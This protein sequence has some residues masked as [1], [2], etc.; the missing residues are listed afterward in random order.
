MP[1][2]FVG[3]VSQSHNVRQNF[4]R[5]LLEF[6]KR[7][8]EPFVFDEIGPLVIA[9]RGL[10]RML[11]GGDNG[12]VLG[13]VAATT[14]GSVAQAIDG[15][16][17]ATPGS[18]AQR[19][20]ETRWGGYVAAFVSPEGQVGIWRAPLG[21]L[22]CYFNRTG[23]DLIV[24][25]SP[26]LIAHCAARPARIDQDALT[27]HLSFAHQRLPVTCL[28][29][30]EELPGGQCL[31]VMAR[32]V[33]LEILWSPWIWTERER[34]IVNPE[35][36][37]SR[38]RATAQACVAACAYSHT[39]ILLKLSGGLDSSIVAACLAQAGLRFRALTLVTDEATG[40]ER[41]YARMVSAHFGVELI[42]VRR[43]PARVDLSRSPAGDLARPSI[44]LFRQESERIA[45]DAARG[46]G[47]PLLMDGGGGDNVFC[48]LQ[49]ASPVA[50]CLLSLGGWRR[51]GAT[52]SSVAEV[53]QVSIAQ[54]VRAAVRRAARRSR[55]HRWPVERSFLSHDA[56]VRLPAKPAHP[57]LRAPQGT[58]P[59]RA[60]HVALIAA[61]QSYVEGLD[62]EREPHLAV[63]LLAQPL[64]E[65]CL[66]IPSWLWF[67][68]GLSRAIARRAFAD[69]LPAAIV[70]RR[71]KGTPDSFVAQVFE[72]NR[73][74]ICDELLGGEL[75][76]LGLLDRAALARV[77]DSRRPLGDRYL[78][79]IMTLYDA[80]IWCRAWH[81]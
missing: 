42:E 67:E 77:L 43:D 1:R 9:S 73:V 59:G 71:S 12:L 30:I 60:A 28:E 56:L 15:N 36:A 66:R 20:I 31:T 57:W 46:A 63:P 34:A 29:D 65:L 13:R 24:A 7:P 10:E 50:D 69:E 61:G 49:S 33:S 79:R 81:R 40:D 55:D 51:L 62:P 80:E 16:G 53:A 27:R 6:G 72:R 25:S 2:A 22:P 39:G 41:R 58:L 45:A 23:G 76:G 35:E 70:R 78:Q 74:R 37:A 17:G 54:V 19:F 75:A 32:S 4:R 44:P 26:R 47:L 18:F 14:S 8:G 38:L 48:S 64:V 5:R 52:V 68:Q 21:D 11:V 3:I